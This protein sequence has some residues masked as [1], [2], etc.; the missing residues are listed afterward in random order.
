MT[1]ALKKQPV[2]GPK[3][4]PLHPA[5]QAKGLELNRQLQ[6]IFP[7]RTN[8]VIDE[9][10]AVLPV[11]HRRLERWKYAAVSGFWSDVAASKQQGLDTAECDPLPIPGLEAY[12][13]VFVNGCFDASNSNL[14]IADGVTCMPLIDAEANGHVTRTMTD[15]ERSDWFAALNGKY[16]VDGVY[17]SL[18]DGVVLD[19]PLVIHQRQ[20]GLSHPTFLRHCIDIGKNAEAK[21]V[22][23]S[24]SSKEASGFVNVLTSAT[25]GDG[26]RLH[27]DKVQDEEGAVHHLAMESITQAANS[28][29]RIQTATIQGV[30]VRNDL[31]IILDGSGSDAILNGAFLPNNTEMVD[32]HTTVDHRM[33]HCVSSESYKGILY[34]QSKGVFNGKVFVRPD[35]QQTSAYQQ[36]ANILASRSASMNAK[37]ELEIYADDV[38]CSHGCTIGQ[39]DDDAMFYAQSRGIG[40][41]EAKS[42]LVYAFIMD[43]LDGFAVEEVSMEVRH[44]LAE[45]HNWNRWD[46]PGD[47]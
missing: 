40:E 13:L 46:A 35:A 24:S 32:N 20:T 34:G 44:R 9:M 27:M 22:M 43:I 30:W 12:R 36:N 21:L 8:D 29:F 39:F 45:K 6:A 7:N 23:W 14:P 15:R 17:L 47:Y 10:L 26:A 18:A 31:A 5:S 2:L 4:L 3:R 33:P 41:A 38:K 1:T 42:M 25:V 37:P 19:R 11:P 28:R 16:A